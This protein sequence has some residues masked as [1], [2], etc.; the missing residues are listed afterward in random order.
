MVEYRKMVRTLI[1]DL[2]HAERDELGKARAR[3]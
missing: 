2:I 3:M 1:H